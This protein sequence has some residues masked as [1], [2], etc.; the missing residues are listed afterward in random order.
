MAIVADTAE[1]LVGQGF[2]P[3]TIENNRGRIVAIV[4]GLTKFDAVETNAPI[5]FESDL[6]FSGYST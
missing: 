1:T 5:L 3:A 6:A 4:A 2:Q